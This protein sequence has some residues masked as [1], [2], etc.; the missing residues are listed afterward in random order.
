MLRFL[1]AFFWCM[2]S[3][4]LRLGLSKL[5]LR[6]SLRLSLRLALADTLAETETLAELRLSLRLWL[7]LGVLGVHTTDTFSFKEPFSNHEPSLSQSLSDSLSQSNS[8]S[9]SLSLSQSISQSQSLSESLSESLSASLESPSLSECELLSH[10]R[11]P[12]RNTNMCSFGS[13]IY[14]GARI[15]SLMR[16][17]VWSIRLSLFVEATKLCALVAK[18]CIY[19]NVYPNRPLRYTYICILGK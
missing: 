16:L 11:T 5:A 1:F 18:K 6:L 12:S 10:T 7:R 2:L 8:L 4:S 3:H 9:Q 13:K 17:V 19:P 14:L 15:S